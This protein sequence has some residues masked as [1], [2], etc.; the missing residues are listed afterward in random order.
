MMMRLISAP[1]RYPFSAMIGAALFAVFAILAVPWFAHTIEPVL[2]PVAT[3]WT[4]TSA[5]RDGNDLVMT[6]TMIKRRPCTYTPPIIVRDMQGQNYRME[7]QSTVRGNTWA[8]S[9][10][11]QRF[12]PWRIYDGAGKKLTFTS[13]Y[14]CHSLWPTFTEL[15]VFDAGN[16]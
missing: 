2:L 1:V 15:G 7:H 14:E 6:G 10:E 11:P 8:P 3:H 16:L 5:T 9:S 13:L 4:V 12:G